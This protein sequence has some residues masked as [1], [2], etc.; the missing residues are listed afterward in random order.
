LIYYCD[1]TP[2]YIKRNNHSIAARGAIESDCPQLSEPNRKFAALYQMVHH[3]VRGV[4]S[5]LRSIDNHKPC[6]A[7]YYIVSTDPV[8]YRGSSDS[9]AGD[10]STFNCRVLVF[11][12]TIWYSKRSNKL[13][14]KSLYAYAYIIVLKLNN[15]LE[16]FPYMV[17]NGHVHSYFLNNDKE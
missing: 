2:K 10:T 16:K 8:R 9:L 7:S 11:S 4:I 6:S 13:H 15:F 5:G 3:T 17:K 12:C 14:K 1:L